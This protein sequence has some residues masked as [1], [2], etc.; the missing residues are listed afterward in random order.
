MRLTSAVRLLVLLALLLAAGVRLGWLDSGRGGMLVLLTMTALVGTT[1]WLI[2]GRSGDSSLWDVQLLDTATIGLAIIVVCGLV[3]GTVGLLHL[4][5]LLVAVALIAILVGAHC[6]APV[7]NTPANAGAW[8]CAPTGGGRVGWPQAV[9]GGLVVFGGAQVVRDRGLLPPVGD[10]AAYHLPFV[11]EWIQHG[12]LVMPVPAAGD[13]S[14]PFYPLNSSLWMHWLTAPFNSDVLARFVQAPFLLLLLLAVV[15]LALEI[16]IPLAGALTAGLLTLTLPDVLRSIATAE[17]DL[18]LAALL[19]AATAN[20]AL[21]HRQPTRWRAAMGA[22]LLGMAAGTKVL[23]MPFV[24]VL[25]LA[26]LLILLRKPGWKPAVRIILIGA[27][28]V[29]LL[30]SYSYL[31]NIVVMGN[32]SYPASISIGDRVLPGLYT[33]TREWRETHPF[34]P[35]DWS[36]FFGFGMRN[37]FGWVV[38]LF[39]LPGLALAAIRSFR[40]RNA[41]VLLLAGWAGLSLALFWFVIPY[42]FER[43]LYATLAWGIVAAI[44]GWLVLMPDRDWWPALVAIPVGLVNVASLPADSGVW[45]RPL[46]LCGGLVLVGGTAITVLICRKMTLP[47]RSGLLMT[48]AALLLVLA[49]PAVGDR[50]EAQRYEQWGRLQSFLGSQPESWSWLRESTADDPATVAV[51]GTNATW[52][53]YGQRLENRVLTIS[54]DG[55]LQTY[56]WGQPFQRF[57]APDQDAWLETVQDSGVDY[58]WITANVSFGEWPNEQGWAGDAG[59]ELL[60]DEPDLQVW[61][62]E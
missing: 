17:N 14:P 23:A 16:R 40:T 59:F 49:W 30:G 58:L 52:A 48:G 8:P 18:I 15:R 19:V 57:G 5:W 46:W 13:P 37:F 50:Y 21:L 9:L 6:H 24:A 35:F 47:R 62:V 33:A 36:G 42:H 56:D 54:H 4:H 29:I 55:V 12:R 28:I 44:W 45:Q 27:G 32:P 26:W 34:Y 41:G 11:A 51:A 61:R 25:G 38:P 20:L 31:R 3:L 1:S 22:M 43:F 10:A 7:P 60:I 53:I 2:A 39:I